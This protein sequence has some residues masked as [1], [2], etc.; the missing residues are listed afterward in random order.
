MTLFAL[1]LTSAAQS[2]TSR[3][4][5]VA[6]ENM[7]T[8]DAGIKRLISKVE[9]LGLR[10]EDIYVVDAATIEDALRNPQAYTVS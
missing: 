3:Q 1:P 6:Q 10:R 8:A 9:S 7:Q 4:G 5:Y 2:K